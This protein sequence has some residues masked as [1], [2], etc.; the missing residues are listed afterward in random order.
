MNTQYN[1]A[2]ILLIALALLHQHFAVAQSDTI[3][4]VEFFDEKEAVEKL[5]DDIENENQRLVRRLADLESQVANQGDVMRVIKTANREKYATTVNT[6][7]SRYDAGERVISHIIKETNQFNLSFSQLELQNEFSTLSDPTTYGEFNFA[8]KTSLDGLKNKRVFPNLSEISDLKT[9]IP[10]LNNPIIS[11]TISIATSLLSRYNQ[12]SKASNEAFAKLTCILDYTNNLKSEHQIVTSRL[13][14]L[15]DKLQAFREQTKGFFGQ[16]LEAIEYKGGYTKYVQD[17]NTLTHDFM[18][19]YREQ[20]FNI[21]H[22]DKDNVGIIT[23]DTP[24]DDDVLFYLEQVKF[25]LNEYENILLEINDFINMYDKFVAKQKTSQNDGCAGFYKETKDIFVR[26]ET[27]LKTVKDNFKIV[28]DE[29]RID[30][31][32][33]R[34]LFGF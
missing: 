12:K 1:I 26:I 27:Q 7:E 21:L 6:L 25:Y 11:T 13:R 3:V 23:Y 5:S 15:N 32:T 24:K 34:I 22:A 18:R 29:N 14:Q 28:Y 17:K 2:A 33:K 30:K 16:Y 19:Q 4:K 9:V 10:V 8:L 31:N 20:F